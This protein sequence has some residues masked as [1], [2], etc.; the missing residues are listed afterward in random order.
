M[1]LFTVKHSDSHS[2]VGSSVKASPGFS[3]IF[4]TVDLTRLVPLLLFL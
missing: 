1:I 2:Y 3:I 4:N